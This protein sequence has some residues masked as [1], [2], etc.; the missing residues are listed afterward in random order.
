MMVQ[1]AG[2]IVKVP[3]KRAESTAKILLWR[4]DD[5]G[6]IPTRYADDDYDSDNYDAY[7]YDSLDY[8][9]DNYDSDNYDSD[10]YDSD[11]YNSDDYND[12]YERRIPV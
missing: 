8:E 3:E 10:K 7:C 11:N 1:R 5:N 2:D 4:A 9:S 12:N 6:G